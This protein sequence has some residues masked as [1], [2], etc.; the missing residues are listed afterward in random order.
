MKIKKTVIMPFVLG[1]LCIAGYIQAEEKL[2]PKKPAKEKP[3]VVILKGKVVKCTVESITKTETRC[4]C[5]V[6]GCTAMITSYKIQ[7]AEVDSDKKHTVNQSEKP[8]IKEG[9]TLQYCPA[10]SQI[11]KKHK[12][13]KEDDQ[14]RPM[15][16][17]RP[18]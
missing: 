5:K 3:K 16:R 8:E 6:G 9:E 7:L 15:L 1:I 18:A 13:P 12:A 4:P 10:T 17:P 11:L 14:R 2:T